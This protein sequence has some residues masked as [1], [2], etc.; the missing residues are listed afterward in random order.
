MGT[1]AELLAR[2]DQYCN[3]KGTKVIRQPILG[4]GSDGAVWQTDRN[5]AVKVLA[6]ERNFNAEL[7]CYLRLKEHNIRDMEGF[8]IPF[9]V[10]YDETLWVIEMP[11]V[12]PPYLL[13]FGKVY[14]DTPPPY[15]DDQQLLAH[16]YQEWQV[17]FGCD[18]PQVASLLKTLE[19]RFGIY[20]VD[21][22]PSNICTGNEDNSDDW[23][24][25]MPP[26]PVEDE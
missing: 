11:I 14:L 7:E 10:G 6:R 5:T 12:R 17:R 8:A 1:D 2:A 9:L 24:R 26:P 20:Y 22:R 13:D 15:H 23:M 21:P 18:W 3:S 25:E 16:A 19:T 4:H